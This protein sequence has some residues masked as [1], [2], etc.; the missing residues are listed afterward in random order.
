LEWAWETYLSGLH[1]IRC[2]PD[3]GYADLTKL[4]GLRD[5]PQ[6]QDLLHRINF[7]DVL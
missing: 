5:H 4:E 7:P 1:Y 3:M 2:V 6:F